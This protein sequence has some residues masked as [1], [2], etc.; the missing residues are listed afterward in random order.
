[1]SKKKTP[2]ALL[3]AKGKFLEAKVRKYGKELMTE[4]PCFFHRFTDSHD[5]GT[6]MGP[7]PGDSMLLTLKDDYL[8][9][10]KES[11]ELSSLSE[12]LNRFLVPT[13]TAFARLWERAGGKAIYVFLD[14]KN[15]MV[16]IWQAKMVNDAWIERRKINIA[17]REKYFELS[18]LKQALIQYCF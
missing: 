3:D 11:I 9:E 10:C 1:M 12:D 4:R 2:A 14:R 16:E 8:V 18:N 13:Q 17:Q 6:I 5:A 15:E 7:T